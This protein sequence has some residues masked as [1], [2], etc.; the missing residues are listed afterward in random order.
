MSIRATAQVL[1][2]DDSP[3]FLHHL[4]IDGLL[5]AVDLSNSATVPIDIHCSQVNANPLGRS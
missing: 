5:I 1:T 4:Q 3:T 2:V